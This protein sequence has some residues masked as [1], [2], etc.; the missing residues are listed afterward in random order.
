MGFG[1]QDPRHLPYAD[2]G[3]T[4]T[5][6]APLL[7]LQGLTSFFSVHDGPFHPRSLPLPQCDNRSA[8]SCI[9]QSVPVPQAACSGQGS[10]KASCFP[11]SFGRP[12]TQRRSLSAGLTF[13]NKSLAGAVDSGAPNPQHVRNFFITQTF[14]RMEEHVGT[15]DLRQ[16]LCHV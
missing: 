2:K 9:V 4:H 6:N 12:L 14:S 10:K 8:N 16:R 11:S 13:F 7:V 1:V 15:G 3:R 5:G